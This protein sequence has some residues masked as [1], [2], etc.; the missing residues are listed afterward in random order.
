MSQGV[1]L[2]TVAEEPTRRLLILGG[3]WSE[4]GGIA[5]RT[6]LLARE[7]ARR[8]WDVRVVGRAGTR[9]RFSLEREPGVRIVDVPGFGRPLIGAPLYIVVVVGS[10]LTWARRAVA[11]FCLQ[12]SSPL[13]AASLGSLFTG[14]PVIASTTSVGEFSEV[15]YLEAARTA[16]LRRRFAR[17]ARWLVGQTEE[18]ARELRRIASPGHVTVLPTPVAVPDNVAP[19]P[20]EKRVAYVGRLSTE[21]HLPELLAAWRK[22]V[23][24]HPD[25]RLDIVG[26]GGSYRD[27]EEQLREIVANDVELQKT[28]RF[29]GHVPGVRY[30]LRG[31]DVFVLPSRT[32]GMSNA[33]L[34]ACA[35]GR[36]IVASRIPGNV[37]VLGDDYP[38]YVPP[39]EAGP[40]ADAISMLLSQP[41]LASECA[42]RSRTAGEHHAVGLVVDRL[43]ALISETP[44]SGRSS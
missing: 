40:L 42:R 28:V 29:L 21:K 15:R 30:L 9:K 2:L 22:V 16:P 41:G 32:E 31:I 8:G 43:I 25:A 27:V 6:R 10:M 19:L 20:G 37:A 39:G 11:V 17:R 24:D 34:E 36:A 23:H 44:E 33:L 13:T 12:L 35:E 7:F 4:R 3:G 14:V 26:D 5:N 1:G 38:L 18:A